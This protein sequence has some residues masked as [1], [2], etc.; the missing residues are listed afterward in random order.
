EDVDLARREAMLGYPLEGVVDR[1]AGLGSEHHEV[2]A[3]AGQP[4]QRLGGAGVRLRVAEHAATVVV[5]GPPPELP[6]VAEVRERGDGI[7]RPHRVERDLRSELLVVTADPAGVE[8]GDDAVQVDPQA[9]RRQGRSGAQY[10]WTQPTTSGTRRWRSQPA[11]A[12]ESAYQNAPQPM[13]KAPVSHGERTRPNSTVSTVK[14]AGRTRRSP[15]TK[16][17][18]IWLTSASRPCSVAW[19]NMSVPS[20][21]SRSGVRIDTRFPTASRQQM[22]PMATG[23]SSGIHCQLDEN[24][25]RRQPRNS[26]SARS[27][28]MAARF[29][30]TITARGRAGRAN[31]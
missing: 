5:A 20:R 14:E 22:V 7:P 29:L 31:R 3:P 19:A 2:M 10:T 21:G 6:H 26:V 16:N 11:T 25:A 1:P 28:V 4:P 15:M 30:P 23:S 13:A 27:P 12:R 9:H 24:Q 8:V 18:T 17:E